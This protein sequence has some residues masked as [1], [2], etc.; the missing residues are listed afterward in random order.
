[1]YKRRRN[2]PAR[3]ASGPRVQYLP[4]Q[5]DYG[6]FS[7]FSFWNRNRSCLARSSRGTAAYEAVSLASLSH[8][9][10]LALRDSTNATALDY[11]TILICYWRVATLNLDQSWTFN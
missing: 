4:T 1:M 5:Q 7:A 11:D 8:S 3:A 9:T 10:L 2:N 6:P